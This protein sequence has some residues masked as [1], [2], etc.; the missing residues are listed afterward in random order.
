MH[1]DGPANGTHRRAQRTQTN[2]LARLLD[3]E[4]H[5]G[6]QK[7]LDQ[8]TT[9]SATGQLPE[10]LDRHGLDLA[11]RILL[12][13]DY[14][15]WGPL[16]AGHP[17]PDPY[18][19]LTPSLPGS[20]TEKARE[21][22]ERAHEAGPRA[23]T[24]E[25]AFAFD[26]DPYAYD[27]EDEPTPASGLDPGE[28]PP[29][30]AEVTETFTRWWTR[31][32][33]EDGTTPR[34]RMPYAFSTHPRSPSADAVLE[35]CR[36]ALG[37][38]A[39]EA[40][41]QRLID[42][43]PLDVGLYAR[44]G[45]L[46]LQ[47]HDGETEDLLYTAPTAGER[48]H[49]LEQALSWYQAAVAVGES[50]LPMGF[51]G[52]L[53]W[54]ADSNRPF[55]EALYDLAQ[56]YWRMGRYNSA[57]R[58]LVTVLYL[59]PAD[60]LG[61]LELLATVRTHRRWHPGICSYSEPRDRV[62]P[63]RRIVSPRGVPTLRY[64]LMRDD[65][66]TDATVDAVVRSAAAEALNATWDGRSD[67]VVVSTPAG[68]VKVTVVAR[69]QGDHSLVPDAHW[70]DAHRLGQ[71]MEGP[72]LLVLV[73]DAGYIAVAQ[74]LHAEQ[75]AAYRAADLPGR[76]CTAFTTTFVHNGTH[77][78]W[79]LSPSLDQALDAILIDHG[80]GSMEVEAGT[81]SPRGFWVEVSGVSG[82]PWF[83]A[84]V[85]GLDARAAGLHVA[86]MARM[87]S[88]E[89]GIAVKTIDSTRVWA[90]FAGTTKRPSGEPVFVAKRGERERQ[91]VQ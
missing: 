60:A 48:R 88:P 45:D 20:P 47:R 49:Y 10:R 16:T 55:L 2:R 74:L 79:D 87:L 11:L 61:A 30:Q 39:Y 3:A 31:K 66:P 4:T 85:E 53:P 83:S 42:H 43:N 84:A 62:P 23:V 80:S 35:T 5:V 71:K 18:Q 44:L 37:D 27:D 56:T 57:E 54:S 50:S 63:R 76:D 38:D 19:S 1:T 51:H 13:Q 32:L 91:P 15:M 17:W 72:V 82:E 68:K 46:A 52:R 64:L 67:H 77:Y 34:F 78:G 41:L 28:V 75:L 40:Q 81:G 8:V 25:G 69:H 14:T 59:D 6:Y 22:L 86:T 7:A 36:G 9:A 24:Q 58:V 12:R 65:E 89:K 29:L 73:A 33:A 26:D 21:A 70:W 90:A